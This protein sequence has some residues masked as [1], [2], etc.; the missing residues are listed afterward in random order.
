[1][2]R[3]Y[4]LVISAGLMWGLIGPLAK[5]AFAAGMNTLEVAFWRTA[6]GWLFFA[7]HALLKG[8]TRMDPRD[9][10]AMLAFGLF[11]VGGLYVFY[12]LA[13]REGGAALAAVLLYTAPAWVA[14]LSRLLVNEP[15]TRIKVAAVAMTIIG[16]LGVSYAPGLAST[17]TTGAVVFGLL[18]GLS[19]ALFYVFGKRWLHQYPTPT[20]F[21][22][23]MPVAALAMLPIIDFA[24]FSGKAMLACVALAA[25]STYGAYSI[26]YAGLRYLEA[27]RAAMAAT[28]EPVAAAI[29][30][31]FMFGETFAW[32]GY[33]GAALILSAVFITIVDSARR[34]RRALSRVAGDE[35]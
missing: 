29:L 31:Y 18:S 2:L 34:H 9:A 30:A 14:V 12:V 11:A 35:G 8:Q 22:Y 27:T 26:Y 33:L 1:M 28:V 25:L 24:P 32:T 16:V 7:A 13:V 20:M 4:M 10:P 15:M 19:Y 3:G 17:I 23:G 5:I 21:L 6:I